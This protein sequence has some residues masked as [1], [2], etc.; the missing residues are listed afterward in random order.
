M[1]AIGMLQQ[2]SKPLCLGMVSN[3]VEE[4]QYDGSSQGPASAATGWGNP[5]DAKMQ[6]MVPDPWTLKVVKRRTSGRGG[7]AQQEEV[8]ACAVRIPEQQ[9]PEESSVLLR[10]TH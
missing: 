8:P 9:L 2:W 4:P 7:A 3:T 1:S 10:L 5:A 6:I